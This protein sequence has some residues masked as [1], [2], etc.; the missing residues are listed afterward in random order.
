MVA[1]SERGMNWEG[2][3]EWEWEVWSGEREDGWGGGRRIEELGR[4]VSRRHRWF[5]I[6]G[7]DEVEEEEGDEEEAEEEEDDD[8]EEEE[9]EEEEDEE[10]ED[11]DDDDE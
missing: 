7:E 3:D 1:K 4:E 5:Q 2:D 8:E 9:E 10:E 11:D 6:S